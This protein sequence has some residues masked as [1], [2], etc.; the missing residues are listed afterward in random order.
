M[1]KETRIARQKLYLS[2]NCKNC[3]ADISKKGIIYTR[4][5]TD[6]VR[7]CQDIYCCRSC[8]IEEFSANIGKVQTNVVYASQL[9]IKPSDCSPAITPVRPPGVAVKRA[10]DDVGINHAT[11][12]DNETENI[13][14]IEKELSENETGNEKQN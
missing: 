9:V 5:K 11:D 13:E 2:M 10:D 12:L 4:L 6:D 3:G 14:S 1:K 8:V 7:T